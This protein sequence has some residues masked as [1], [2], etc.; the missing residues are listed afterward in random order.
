MGMA[1]YE[2]MA[3]GTGDSE[4][5]AAADEISAQVASLLA[6]STA[7]SAAAVDVPI[8]LPDGW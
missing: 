5:T 2:C 7:V 3:V 8:W 4:T 1:R 6:S